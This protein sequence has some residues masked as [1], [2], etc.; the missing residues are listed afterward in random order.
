MAAV[1]L[2]LQF[3]SDQ[4]SISWDIALAYAAEYGNIQM[5]RMS[6]DAGA[7]TSV[8]YARFCP[9]LPLMFYA[10]DGDHPDIVS[11]LLEWGEDIECRDAPA[12]TP[13]IYAANMGSPKVLEILLRRGADVNARVANGHSALYWGGGCSK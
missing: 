1:R 2:L 10:V 11:L 6:R 8:K 13:L 5:V 9:D 12:A 7:L 4:S 3:D